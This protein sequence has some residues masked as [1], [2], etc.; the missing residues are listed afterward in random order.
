MEADRLC[1]FLMEIDFPT[2]R[3]H[4]LADLYS[5]LVTKLRGQI[6]DQGNF[7]RNTSLILDLLTERE[8][9]DHRLRSELLVLLS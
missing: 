7:A 1:A 8:S 9:F 2:R 4:F 3:G 6:S 5:G